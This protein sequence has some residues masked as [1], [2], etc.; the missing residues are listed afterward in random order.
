MIK[1]SR[2]WFKHQYKI[3]VLTNPI[4]EILIVHGDLFICYISFRTIGQQGTVDSPIFGGIGG[5]KV[6]KVCQV[7]FVVNIWFSHDAVVHFHK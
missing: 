6:H 2:W 5:N 3:R 1:Q 4:K 7:F